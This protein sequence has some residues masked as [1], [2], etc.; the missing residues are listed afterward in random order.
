V[1][2]ER[3]DLEARLAKA[4]A[5]RA[6]VAQARV[7]REA[8]AEL[9]ALVETEERAAKDEAAVAAA[10][11]AHGP[12]GRK[13]AVVETDLGVIIVKRPNPVLF[14]KWQDMGKA[15]TATLDQLVRPCLVYPDVAA[16]DRILDELPAT[17]MRLANEVCTLAGMRREEVSG[18]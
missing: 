15:T 13:I 4:R 1:S 5:E 17:L 11:Q 7:E 12:V 10:E 3:E 8:A 2:R 18:K 14:R 16:F 9:A 6:A